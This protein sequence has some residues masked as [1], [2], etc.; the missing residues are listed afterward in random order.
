M[1][2]NLLIHVHLWLE[3]IFKVLSSPWI[4]GGTYWFGPLPAQ[5]LG[6]TTQTRTVLSC[7]KTSNVSLVW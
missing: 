1:N 2:T 5:F 6:F 3:H 4:G 7:V